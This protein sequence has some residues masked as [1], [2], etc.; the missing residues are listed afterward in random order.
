MQ[1]IADATQTIHK[2]PNLL[3]ALPNILLIYPVALQHYS[4][5]SYLC[6]IDTYVQ[7]TSPEWKMVVSG[8]ERVKID[9]KFIGDNAVAG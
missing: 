8:F 1:F 7:A 6:R 5:T 2:L 4:Q 3:Y 9:P